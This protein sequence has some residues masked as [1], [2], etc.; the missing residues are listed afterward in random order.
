MLHFLWT[1]VRRVE[2]KGEE[3]STLSLKTTGRIVGMLSLVA[4]ELSD[5]PLFYRPDHMTKV[6]HCHVP[7]SIQLR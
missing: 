1:Q 5:S 4:E 3:E 6:L 7:S 2:E